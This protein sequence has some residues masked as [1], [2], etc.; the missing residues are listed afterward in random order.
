MENDVV[1]IVKIKDGVADPMFSKTTTRPYLCGTILHQGDGQFWFEIN[2]SKA[3]AIIPYCYV[4][5]MAP[6]R[7]HWQLKMNKSE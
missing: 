4:E 3:L 1:Y 2:G 7:I 6:S 5:W